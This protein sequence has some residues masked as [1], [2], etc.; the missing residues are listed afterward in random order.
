MVSSP[1][2][3]LSVVW[4]VSDSVE[5]AFS[6]YGHEHDDVTQ[7]CENNSALTYINVSFA[8]RRRGAEFEAIF[9]FSYNISGSFQSLFYP[10]LDSFQLLCILT[11][12]SFTNEDARKGFEEM[13]NR[14]NVN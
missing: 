4:I 8:R 11:S 3:L 2:S 9:L 7:K 14:G 1:L 6:L 5:W 12:L 10:S 13:R